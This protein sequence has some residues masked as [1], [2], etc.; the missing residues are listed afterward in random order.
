MNEFNLVRLR[1]TP[2][3]AE[4]E[5][6]NG[7]LRITRPNSDKVYVKGEGFDRYVKCI[8]YD[9]HFVALVDNFEKYHG[10]WF[11]YCSCGAPAVVLG[12]N[13]YKHGASASSGEG[14]V[15]GEMLACYA[16]IQFGKHNDGS[17]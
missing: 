17:S 8:D 3:W 13:A 2:R 1:G 7:I 11:A 10:A 16:H 5:T 15:P 4:F 9:N 14:I 12:Y 6:K